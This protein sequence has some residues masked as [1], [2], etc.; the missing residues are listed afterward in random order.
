MARDR[1]LPARDARGRFIPPLPKQSRVK[2]LS[3]QTFGQLIVIRF[4]GRRTI[5]RGTRAKWLCKCL[6]CNKRTVT[7]TNNLRSGNTKSCG[8]LHIEAAVTQCIKRITHGHAIR[9]ERGR[10]SSEYTA[11]CSA[12]QRCN[13]RR[14]RRWK[15][16]GGATPPVRFLYTSFQQFLNEVGCKPIVKGVRFSLGRKADTGNYGVGLGN[17]WQT[18]EQQIAARRARRN[19]CYTDQQAKAA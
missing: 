4:C 11:Y 1:E 9:D 15:H 16:Y 2:D 19:G 10:V 3:G 6:R 5:K 12:R 7:T 17:A 8:C 18:T 14:V 13:D